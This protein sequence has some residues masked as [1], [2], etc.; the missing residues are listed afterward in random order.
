MAVFTIDCLIAITAINKVITQTCA[1][2]VIPISAPDRII[3]IFTPD[4]L[5]PPTT[6]DSFSI[7]SPVHISVVL[8]LPFLSLTA[9]LSPVL[10][11]GNLGKIAFR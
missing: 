1:N 6:I 11:I 2:G 9:R 10:I 4:A 3:A 8:K 5:G 7:V